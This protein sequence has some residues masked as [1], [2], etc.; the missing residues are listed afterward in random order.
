[1]AGG[2]ARAAVRD[3]L[4]ALLDPGPGE[5]L[6]QLVGAK[7]SPVGAQVAGEGQSIVQ[8]KR[9]TLANVQVR[10]AP[11]QLSVLRRNGAV[12]GTSR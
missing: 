10:I 9:E 3:D 1:M 8:H 4:G 5:P 2:H 11:L 7:E 12:V 6:T